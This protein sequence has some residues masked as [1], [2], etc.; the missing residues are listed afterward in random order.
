M[1]NS[2]A[3][4]I[5]CLDELLSDFGKTCPVDLNWKVYPHVDSDLGTEKILGFYVSLEG[6][7]LRVFDP[8]KGRWERF[9]GKEIHF[10]ISEENLLGRLVFDEKKFWNHLPI[11]RFGDF[12][13][14]P[15]YIAL[16]VE[17]ALVSG[18]ESVWADPIED[19][20]LPFAQYPD[21]ETESIDDYPHVPTSHL[22]DVLSEH[23]T[24]AL[25]WL[26]AFSK[27]I[28]N[29]NTSA[30][31]REST[32]GGRIDDSERENREEGVGRSRSNEHLYEFF[33]RS[34]RE[35]ARSLPDEVF[36][37]DLNSSECLR[38]NVCPMATP[39]GEAEVFFPF[40]IR[41]ARPVFFPFCSVEISPAFA[42]YLYH[43][44]LLAADLPADLWPLSI[45]K[46]ELRANVSSKVWCFSFAKQVARTF[47]IR[48][49]QMSVE[50]EF[51]RFIHGESGPCGKSS[52]DRIEF[53]E[54]LLRQFRLNPAKG[55]TYF[56]RNIK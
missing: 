17:G 12:S 55:R 4:I 56:G 50:G 33:R 42:E 15:A 36:A 22:M 48:A 32:P 24:A 6:E 27:E 47:R 18:E 44:V 38:L 52:G 19:V 14:I 1:E 10:T 2:W 29:G 49:L 37:R 11:L 13:E 9:S 21:D 30:A 51:Q 25:P 23:C 7:N 41:F 39:E 54:G 3:K 40:L 28:D 46:E 16:H 45:S 20:Y 8:V 35:H 43:R 5:G 31:M 34:V 26:Y 53:L